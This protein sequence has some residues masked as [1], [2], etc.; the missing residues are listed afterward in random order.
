MDQAAQLQQRLLAANDTAQGVQTDTQRSATEI[1]RLTS[2]GQQRLGTQ[3]RMLSASQIRPMVLQMVWNLQYFGMY[4][5]QVQL[6]PQYAKL[7]NGWYEWK[8]KEILGEFDYLLSDGTLP[9]DPRAN[10]ENL[11]RAIRVIG[12]TNTAANWNMAKIFNE[13][14][15]SMGFSDVEEWQN[16]Q[17]EAAAQTAQQQA[18]AMANNPG[19]AAQVAQAQQ[20]MG[21]TK[22]EVQ[23]DEQV[24]RDK[25]AGNVVPLSEAMRT[26]AVQ[27][28]SPQATQPLQSQ[29]TQASGVR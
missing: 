21:Q 14:F 3:A 10:S 1:A 18:G 22:A 11:M 8:Q 7:E 17:K 9:A 16:T 2:L 13:L 23:P 25:Q 24:M 27:Q 19:V 15:V 12:E 5:G 20:Q 4:G 29:P 28:S 26:T 6:P